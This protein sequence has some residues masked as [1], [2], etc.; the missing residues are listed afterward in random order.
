MTS[1]RFA[2]LGLVTPLLAAP[3][4]AETLT[5]GP[6]AL[7]FGHTN[8]QDAVDAAMPGDT[9][10]VADG[11]YDHF[12]VDKPL[13]VLGSGSD[14]CE[15]RLDDTFSGLGLQV[16]NVDD[17]FARV[18]GFAFQPNLQDLD[19]GSWVNV[20]KCKAPVEVFDLDLQV[21]SA[22]FGSTGFVRVYDSRQ[23]V[24]SA[25]RVS[26][27]A[28]FGSFPHPFL[29][30]NGQ[31]GLFVDNSTVW[32]SDCA[33]EGSPASA[34]YE[35]PP[36]SVPRAG[37]GAEVVEGALFL[38]NS[39]LLGGQGAP[40]MGSCLPI[41]S[42]PGL[43]GRFASM[44]EVHT[45]PSSAIVGGLAPGD[46]SPGPGA[47]MG[48]ASALY[49]GSGD[50]PQGGLNDDGTQGEAVTQVGSSL[51]LQPTDGVRPTLSADRYVLSVGSTA[52]FEHSGLPN[53]LH[54][55]VLSQQTSPAG[56]SPPTL[57]KVFVDA[58]Q[59]QVLAPLFLDG[60]GTGTQVVDVPPDP[61][62][63]GYSALFQAAQSGSGPLV[64][65]TPVL[66]AIS[67]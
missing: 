47:L 54:W 24:L 64:F 53:A 35:G 28:S 42:G 10:L 4:A 46:S 16:V 41:D 63:V 14:S 27:P 6:D 3:L 38:S 13:S 15:L 33:F 62:L 36:L 66:L 50:L 48:N 32:A 23:V 60:Q 31:H 22:H 55:T 5:V 8:I 57:G 43:R 26:G 34:C 2:F 25:V 21:Q 30:L 9:V 56:L 51:T 39:A 11:V 59:A 65:S 52:T 29:D 7:S 61:N 45:G 12:I 58:A 17:G 37:A 44:I 67:S 19:Q 49:Y 40:T 1:N 18:G 20:G